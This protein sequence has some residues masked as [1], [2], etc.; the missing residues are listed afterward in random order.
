MSTSSKVL[1]ILGA[2]FA[3]LG[4]GLSLL[5]SVLSLA[6]SGASAGISGA[7]VAASL[8]TLE[9]VPKLCSNDLALAE[10][11]AELRKDVTTLAKNRDELIEAHNNLV[12]AVDAMNVHNR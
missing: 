10:S 11:V 1:S 8:S 9:L 2:V 12:K 5:L 6:V 7:G 4:I 3:S